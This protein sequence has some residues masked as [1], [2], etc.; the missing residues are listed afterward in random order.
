MAQVS[1]DWWSSLPTQPVE[2]AAPTARERK[3]SA[4]ATV[5]ELTAEEKRQKIAEKADKTAAAAEAEGAAK[6]AAEAAGVTRKNQMLGYL[7]T[8][9]RVRDLLSSATATGPAGQ[10]LGNIWGSKSGDLAEGLRSLQNPIV[11]EAMAEARKGSKVGA[12]GFGALSEKELKLLASTWGS[13]SQAQSPEQLKPVLD[14]LE[15]H[16]K[17]FF[18]YN[19]GYDPN[20]PEGALLVGLPTPQGAEPAAPEGRVRAGES[21]QPPEIA[22]VDAAVRSMVKGGRSADQIRQWLREYKPELKLDEKVA[23]LD[24]NIDYFKKTGKLPGVILESTFKPSENP[25]ASLAEGPAGAFALSA[26]DQLA[27][28]FLGELTG[29][30]S[31]ASAIMR[32]MREQ[33]PTAS[34][35]GDVAGGVGSALTGEAL[36]AR[37]GLRLPALLQGLPQELLYGAGSAEPGERVSGMVSQGL[38]APVTNVVGQLAGKAIGAPLRGASEQAG[39]LMDKY[40]IQLTPGMLSGREGAERTMAGWPIVGSQVRER[41]NEA[42]EQFNRAAFDEGL[43]PIGTRTS[44][45]GQ[46]GIADAQ[47]AVSEAYARALGGVNLVLDQPFAQQARGKAYSDLA[48]LRDIGPELSQE[49]DAIFGRYA[50]PSGTISGEGLQNALQEFQTLKNSYKQDPR[51]AK[52]IAPQ[53]DDISDAYAGLLERQAPENF[54]LFQRANT[55]YRNVSTLEK[56]VETAAEGDIFN[57]GNLRSATRQQTQKFGGKKASA[58]GDRPFNE[59][60]MSALNV[61]PQRLDDVSMVGRLAAPVVLGGAGAGYGLV[62]G[63]SEPSEGGGKSDE[64]S[65]LPAPAVYGLGAA[66]LAALPY[67][68][69]GMRGLTAP[70]RGGRTPA[71]ANLGRLIEQYLPAAVRGSVRGYQAEPGVPMPQNF[72]YSQVGSPE[73][74][75]IVEQAAMAP[76]AAEPTQAAP[77]GPSVIEIG[78]RRVVLDLQSGTMVDAETGEPVEGFAHGGF[79]YRIGGR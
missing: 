7:G 22:G 61:V 27:G 31:R 57:P 4:E 8:I 79:A 14:R 33:N 1:E 43:A 29:D 52:R 2:K 36:A 46:K 41:R 75:N 71:A 68:K 35:I 55:A 11:L 39:A 21:V 13:L 25:L 28:G 23:N 30:Q 58:R 63:A 49:V 67:S 26:A 9:Q 19:A 12:T 65:A 15:N 50:D 62:S 70:M 40:G 64:A 10:V 5:S 32:G 72:D 42:L 74:R 37:Y 51:W 53:L 66:A 38:M 60:T 24:Q 45:V 18:A 16:Y 34:A 56:A 20:K 59:L 73:F 78:G 6:V 54:N 44:A 3:E 76:P 47:Q 69:F 48:K 17:R 77:A